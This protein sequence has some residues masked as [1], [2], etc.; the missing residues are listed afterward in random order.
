M[1]PPTLKLLELYAE[2]EKRASEGPWQTEGEY[3]LYVFTKDNET[4]ILAGRGTGAG[5]TT[6]QQSN[7]CKLAAHARNTM[8][9]KDEMIRVLYEALKLRKTLPMIES[10]T[11]V[12]TFLTTINELWKKQDA[13]ISRCDAIAARILKEN[14]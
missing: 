5:L 3:D 13:A 9:A 1:T 2:I 4:M 11:T 8:Q 12:G 10:D 6:E 14:E 7:N